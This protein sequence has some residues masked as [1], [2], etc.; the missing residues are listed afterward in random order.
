[1]SK[2][3][4]CQSELVVG[5]VSNQ[6]QVRCAR[7]GS[8]SQPQVEQGTR[9]VNRAARWSLWLGLSSIL[10]LWITGIPALILGIRALWQMRYK[11]PTKREKESAIIGTV[12]G[13]TFGL[14]LGGCATGA[15]AMAITIAIN[16]MPTSTNDPAVIR[17]W[18][19]EVVHLDLPPE[20]EATDAIWLMSTQ[21]FEFNKAGKPYEFPTTQLHVIHIGSLLANN[22]G[23][24][25]SFQDDWAKTNLTVRQGHQ[26][27]NSEQ[28]EWNLEGA[29]TAVNHETF[30]V[31]ADLT[32]ELSDSSH[33]KADHYIAFVRQ[34]GAVVGLQLYTEGPDRMDLGEVRQL[35]E[36][37]E[38]VED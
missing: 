35:F 32:P 23:L 14:L 11:R 21:S 20:L 17:Q 10:L 6:Q 22:P 15:L 4:R 3:P 27:I 7:G 34:R 19:D 2:C 25:K 1:M 31:P 29:A 24:L 13:T 28:L 9:Q 18:M 33:S 26:L 30:R 8:I 38:I 37:L 16:A 5:L 12:L 36:S